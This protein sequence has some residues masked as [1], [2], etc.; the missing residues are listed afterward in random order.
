MKKL[1]KRVGY[2]IALLFLLL[3]ILAAVHAY[4]FTHFYKAGSGSNGVVFKPE[5]AG[6]FQKAK[7]L[8]FG[9]KSYRKANDDLPSFR[10]TTDTLHTADGF[11]LEFWESMDPCYDTVSPPGT[12]IMF[13]GHGGNK[14]GMINEAEAFHKLG[15]HIVM[16]DF[17]AHGNSS[18]EV[19]TIGYDEAKDVKAAYDFVSDKGNN[20]IIFYGISLGAAAEMK[21]VKDYRLHPSKMI[22]EMPFGSL[23]EAV[24]GRCRVMHVPAQPTAALLTFW[25][26]VEQGFWA[27]DHNPE[28][29]AKAIDCAVL[30]Q[31]GEKDVRVTKNETETIFRN[32]RSAKKQLVT[33]AGSGHQSLC[34]NEKEKWIN[35]VSSFLRQ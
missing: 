25:G 18:G 28:D 1:L 19:C 33:Y 21:A 35:T 9:V 30:L 22:L 24:K 12:V 26:G 6:F 16:V 17:R 29:Y 31:W 2:F 20:N 14:A 11:Q 15:Y 4:K 34:S 8:M 10:F 7:A 32:L 5:D 27:F 23:S 13:H 3:N